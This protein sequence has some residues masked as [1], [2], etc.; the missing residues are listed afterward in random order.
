MKCKNHPDREA[1]AVCDKHQVGFCDECCECEDLASCCGCLDP[2]SHCQFRT[3]C[4]IWELSR[5]RRRAVARDGQDP[6]ERPGRG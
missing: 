4:L 3:Q 2:T 5:E 6:D 1:I